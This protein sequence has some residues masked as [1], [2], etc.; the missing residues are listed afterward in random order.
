MQLVITANVVGGVVKGVQVS[1][2]VADRFLC[3]GL[4]EMARDAI[5]DYELPAVEV[6]DASMT[7][8]LLGVN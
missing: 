6:P 2:P 7:R 3:Y 8:R 4:I 1:G 5:R